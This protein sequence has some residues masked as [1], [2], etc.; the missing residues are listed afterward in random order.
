MRRPFIRQKKKRQKYAYIQDERESRNSNGLS[1]REDALVGYVIWI[2]KLFSDYTQFARVDM[3][4]RQKKNESMNQGNWTLCI[5]MYAE[6]PSNHNLI[7]GG[8]IVYQQR[9][10]SPS[11]PHSKRK[12]NQIIFSFIK[13][14]RLTMTIDI[15]RRIFRR[16]SCPKANDTLSVAQT[17]VGYM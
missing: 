11:L 4:M 9:H 8:S 15:V 14:L 12:K 7:F 2:A 16:S 6:R 13:K 5:C 17:Q 1:E 3:S 10:V